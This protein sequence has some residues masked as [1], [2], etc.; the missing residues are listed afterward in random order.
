MPAAMAAILI[1]SIL[2]RQRERL[3]HRHP[4]RRGCNPMESKRL[5]GSFA[6][7]VPAEAPVSGAG[8]RQLT[9]SVGEMPGVLS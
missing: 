6:P 1:A 4:P 2:C 7:F 9:K 5:H 8:I 3:S